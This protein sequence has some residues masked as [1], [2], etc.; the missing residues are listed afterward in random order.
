MKISDKDYQNW[1]RK[2]KCAKCGGGHWLQDLGEWRCE[3]AHTRL[4]GRGGTAL[5]PIY[6]GIPLCHECHAKTH[7]KGLSEVFTKEECLIL[8]GQYLRNY[9]IFKERGEL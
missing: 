7:D 4:N 2:Q 3:Y 8:T 9:I 5:K 6:S 1:C